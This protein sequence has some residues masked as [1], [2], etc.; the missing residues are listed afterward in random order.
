MSDDEAAF[1][2]AL[3][4]NP[5]DDTARL[6]FADWLDDRNDP[7]GNWVRKKDFCTRLMRGEEFVPMLCDALRDTHASEAAEH[8]ARF[9]EE[10]LLALVEVAANSNDG[11]ARYF[12]EGAFWRIKDVPKK[13]TTRWRKNLTSPDLASRRAALVGLRV[14]RPKTLPSG[15]DRN[16]ASADCRERTLAAK[17]ISAYGAR[18]EDLLPHLLDALDNGGG[19]DYDEWRAF[20][21]E[22][23]DAIC[24]IGHDAVTDDLLPRIIPRLM[25]GFILG[26]NQAEASA[27]HLIGFGSRVAPLVLDN[28]HRIDTQEYGYAVWVLH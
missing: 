26:A 14:A 9:G 2:E 21:E 11:T 20:R 17:L 28:I 22:A 12:A 4:A 23:L 1:W 25:G 18:A 8:L 5:G 3:K 15:L 7:R 13:P 24:A 6:V 27:H 19:F 16:L 10:G